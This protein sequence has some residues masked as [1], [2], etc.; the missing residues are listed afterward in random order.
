MNTYNK[1]KGSTFKTSLKKPL[2]FA[3]SLAQNMLLS[4]K[5][6]WKASKMCFVFRIFSQ[7]V[8]GVRS[9]FLLYISKAIIDVLTSTNYISMDE[10]LERTLFL[11]VTLFLVEVILDLIQRLDEIVSGIHKER[12]HYS[13]EVGMIEKTIEL[14][15]AYFDTPK[16]YD[17]LQN[18]GNDSGALESL[19]WLSVDIIR[20]CTQLIS[21]IA[22]LSMLNWLF[23]LLLIIL[24]IPSIIQDKNFTKFIYNWNRKQVH[25][26]RKLGYLRNIS[27]DKLFA[28]DFR[29]FNIQKE[30]LDRY[31]SIW[32]KWF[33]EKKIITIKKGLIVAAMSILPK[34]GSI[35]VS[36]YVA[37]G[38]VNNR[39]TIGDFSFYTGGAVQMISCVYMIINTISRLYDN[40]IRI[41]NYKEFLSFKPCIVKGENNIPKTINEVEFRNVSFTY[42]NSDKYILRNINLTISLKDK[43][44]IVGLNGAGK[45]TLIKLLLR[46]YDPTEGSILIDGTDISTYNEEQYRQRF[47]VMFQEFTKYAFSIKDNIT[48]SEIQNKDDFERLDYAC[49]FSEVNEM[50]EKLDCNLDTFLTRQFEEDGMELSGGEWQKIMIARAF[51]R[52]SQM[53]ILDEPTSALDPEAESNFFKHIAEL[54][55]DKGIVYISHRLSNVTMADKIYVIE[56]GSIIEQGSH[57]ELM[58]MVGRY[59]Y[60]F[61]LQAEKY[62]A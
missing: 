42:P 49:K 55:S 56:N 51:F 17:N 36:V 34:I 45:S 47:G 61:N 57:Y 44:A 32:G 10:K 54:C 41:S 30:I 62:Q 29:I 25:E 8:Y 2:K 12:I 7:L 23:P 40:E 43:I 33:S 26:M 14:D 13:V 52:Q 11:L 24:S 31:K 50:L 27:L 28:K 59:S 20:N 21:A 35:V 46:L 58:K 19:A 48:L 15:L 16:F 37:S 4:F 38:I 5:I 39:F 18:A 53:M 22:I 3:S 6:S 60:L 1:E 9:V